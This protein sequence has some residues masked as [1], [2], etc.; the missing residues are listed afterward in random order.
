MELSEKINAAE[1]K[2]V[3]EF[4]EEPTIARIAT[5]SVLDKAPI[6]HIADII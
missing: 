6:V 1:N 2:P 4:G 3:S 5:R